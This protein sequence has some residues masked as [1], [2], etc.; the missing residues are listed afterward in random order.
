MKRNRGITLIALVVTI[1][2][3]II[4]AGISINL[5]LGENGIVTKAKVAKKIYGKEEVREKVSLMMGEYAPNRHENNKTLADYLQEQQ[6]AGKIENTENNEDGTYSVIIDGYIVTIREENLEII[7]ISQLGPRPIVKNI[8]IIVVNEENETEIEAKENEVEF[9]TPLKITFDVTF[10]EGT[11]EAINKGTLTEG[12]VEYITDGTE[13]SVEFI[14]TGKIGEEEVRKV[15]RVPLEKFYM[16]VEL[17]ASDIKENPT[18]YYGEIV[19]NYTCTSNGVAVWRIYYADENNIYLI[20]DDYIE[21]S[22]MPNSLNGNVANSYGTHQIYFEDIYTDET[23]FL[24][25]K[26][27]TENSK[28]K[29]WLNEYLTQ[30]PSK[31]ATSMKAVAYLLDTNIWQVYAGSYADYAI[32]TPTIELFCASYKDTHPN[33][34][35]EYKVTNANGYAVKLNSASSYA[36]S[37]AGGTIEADCNNIYS[38]PNNRSFGMWISSP[39]AGST[40]RMFY[41]GTSNLSASFPHTER[42]FGVRP[43]VCLN[44]NITLE[45]IKDGYRIKENR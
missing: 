5:L 12:K 41:L 21:E 17:E 29:K 24:G 43:V 25:N 33:R 2:V 13:K 20:A 23:Y 18:K 7:D 4:L 22:Q 16:K 19:T 10:E 45:K 39:N 6:N 37:T 26:W 27:I 11:L 15:Q 8:K 36:E 40:S 38:I 31:S 9:G 14:I 3:L 42:G 35:I 32:G 34:Y 1:I 28:A 44:S 30:N